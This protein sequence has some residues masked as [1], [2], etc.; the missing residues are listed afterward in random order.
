M[1]AGTLFVDDGA[2]SQREPVVSADFVPSRKGAAKKPPPPRREAKK[3]TSEPPK[4][5]LPQTPKRLQPDWLSEGA[6][7]DDEEPPSSQGTPNLKDLTTLAPKPRKSDQE[8]RTADEDG[9]TSDDVLAVGGGGITA[10]LTGVDLSNLPAAPA[11]DPRAAPASDDDD[12]DER[13]E[14]RSPS[15]RP[16]ARPSR[17]RSERPAPKRK[18]REQQKSSGMIWLVAA[19][20]GVVAIWW[21]FF[22][23]PA[24]TTTE[25]PTPSA[26][27]SPPPTETTVS[28]PTTSAP[29]VLQPAEAP[30]AN[31]AS[32]SNTTEQPA[33]VTKKEEPVTSK[34]EPVTKKEEPVTKKEEPTGVDMA[35]AFDKAAA[36]SALS[37][38]A[39]SAS[40][41]R[42][43]GDPT[44]TAVVI[45]TFAPSGR[46]TSANI[47]GPP[48]AGT[49][50]GG[51]I[52][53]AMRRAK[54]PAFSGEYVTVSKTVVIQ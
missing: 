26:E 16:S 17:T 5:K 7:A 54:I 52:A 36:S 1:S 11:S 4:P 37:G 21:L 42:Q 28:V 8:K 49:K 46:V 50:T 44:G 12:D 41:C 9:P 22:R 15:K 31:L 30:D 43:E 27:P 38:A 2:G 47:T 24:S 10:Q 35:P 20:L 34:E 23:P 45:V 40:A 25:H 14:S 39:G 13:S 33:P 19:G 48:F 32:P 18:D 29:E 6:E 51:C 3:P 53:A